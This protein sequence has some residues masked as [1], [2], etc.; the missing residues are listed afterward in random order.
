MDVINLVI[1][2]LVSILGIL[3][4]ILE[5]EKIKKEDKNDY[6]LKAMN[7]KIFLAI[8]TFIIAGIALI[9]KELYIL[10]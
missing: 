7:I 3:L 10:F 1:G 2:I 9:L 8:W 6:L 5:R 4:Y